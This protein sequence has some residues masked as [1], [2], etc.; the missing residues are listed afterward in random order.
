MT[1]IR[2]QGRRMVIVALTAAGASGCALLHARTP[3][4]G[5][6]LEA[7][8]APAHVVPPPTIAESEPAPAPQPAAAEPAPAPAS[9][10]PRQP[11]AAAPPA[12]VPAAPDA[13]PDTTAAPAPAPTLQTT[14]D[15]AAA[16]QRVRAVLDRASRDLGQVNYQGLSADGKTQYRGG[17]AIHSAGRGRARRAECPVRRT[18]RRQ[19]GG[20]GNG[21]ALVARL[22]SS[23]ASRQF[24]GGLAVTAF[25]SSVTA[26]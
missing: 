15:V 4:P 10:A 25:H 13:V 2:E 1:G 23:V 7:P 19:G 22:K 5:P 9:P 20:D 12:P 24:P 26:F 14:P 17:S 16:V 6:G 8:A 3:Q 21:A 11:A 18:A